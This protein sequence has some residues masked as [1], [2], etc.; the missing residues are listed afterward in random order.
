MGHQKSFT[1]VGGLQSLDGA[2]QS[3]E[4]ERKEEV[5]SEGSM[6]SPINDVVASVE[7]DLGFDLSD[8]MDIADVPLPPEPVSELVDDEIKQD[9]AFKFCFIG[10][11][12]GGGNIAQQFYQY[13]Y[14]R[15]CAVNT[16]D[17]DLRP[18]QLPD[19][20]KCKLIGT[21]EGAGGD[22]RVGEAAAKRNREEI[23]NLMRNSFGAEF[24]R[25]F[26]TCTAGGG[27]GAGS[28]EE[29][30]R[31]AHHLVEKLELQDEDDH[32]KV[33]VIVAL[34]KE[35]DGR[36][37]HRS[38]YN[39][40]KRLVEL[41]PTLISPLIIID[42]QRVDKLY[43]KTPTGKFWSKANHACCSI[44]HLLNLVAARESAYTSFDQSDYDSILRSGILAYGAMPV[45][46]W[47]NR[48]AV[49]TAIRDNLTRN[50]LV[51]G[52]DF[53]TGN[54]AGCVVVGG[55]DTLDNHLPQEYL[56]NGFSMLNRMIKP[57]SA[58]RR[59]VYSGGNDKS[60]IVYTLI[61]GLDAPADRL[62]E[63]KRLGGLQDHDGA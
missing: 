11:G 57:G 4:P 5:M 47:D 40:I 18:L 12:Q 61:G 17:A 58:V 54:V 52:M 14:R 28:A 51:G 1:L 53:E 20:N 62:A 46:S 9:T 21:K 23:F 8:I 22:P 56:D 6:D 15:V 50:V 35:A 63:L 60:L 48:D 33:G 7:E 38:A 13:G 2:P 37:A 41:T 36:D 26:V 19:N 42:N 24:D 10:S 16:A 25:I 29:V 45:T 31:I 39:T 49:S 59:G 30:V 55:K 27:T 3:R 43:P 32:S 34:P 44:F